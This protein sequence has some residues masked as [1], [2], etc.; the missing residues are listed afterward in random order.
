MTK[1]TEIS[2]NEAYRLY[3]HRV[4]GMAFKILKNIQMAE[5]V[6]QDVFIK[7]LKQ[8]PEKIEEHQIQW[9]CVVARNTSLKIVAK[10]KKFELCESVE[11]LTDKACGSSEGA[12]KYKPTCTDATICL[13]NP[14]SLLSNTERSNERKQATL[15]AIAKLSPRLQ[16]LIKLRFFDQLSYAEI[17]KKTKLSVG[18]VGFLLNKA[19]TTLRKTLNHERRTLNE[20]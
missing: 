14:Y 7:F 1:I 2:F 20:I 15:A 9:L 19:T 12:R 10:T 11:S 4:F 3:H 17:A 16:K 6:T 8:P 5:D 13:D 18:N